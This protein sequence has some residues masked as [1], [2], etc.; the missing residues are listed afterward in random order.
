MNVIHTNR[1]IRCL[2]MIEYPLQREW[3]AFGGVLVFSWYLVHSLEANV[4]Q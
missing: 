3:H 2:Q 1:L 4:S